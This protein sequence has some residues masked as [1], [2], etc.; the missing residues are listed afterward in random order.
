M[1][2]KSGAIHRTGLLCWLA[3]PPP[4][5]PQI[6]AKDILPPALVTNLSAG[7]RR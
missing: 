4:P 3:T 7:I 6:P 1:Y 2:G 5:P